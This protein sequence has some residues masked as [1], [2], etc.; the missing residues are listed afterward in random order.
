MGAC[1]DVCPTGALKIIERESEAYDP[2]KTY[3]H[4]LKTR[5]KDA[6]AQVHG[7]EPKAGARLRPSLRMPEKLAC[8]CPGSLAREITP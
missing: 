5:G 3:Q 1:L 4:V 8:G 6:A 7:A 2:K